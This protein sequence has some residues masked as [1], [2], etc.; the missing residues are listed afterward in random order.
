MRIIAGMLI[1]FAT[2]SS[3]LPGAKDKPD[4]DVIQG[5]WT[6]VSIRYKGKDVPAEDFSDTRARIDADTIT[7]VYPG[8]ESKE[9]KLS[10]RLNA[11]G[12]PRS[13]DLV[14]KFQAVAPGD[15]KPSE[16]TLQLAGIYEI[17]G[18]ELKLCWRMPPISK[19]G[20]ER[21][22]L[23]T[24]KPTTRPKNFTAKAN[25]VLTLRRLDK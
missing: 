24:G 3:S 13:I 12:L 16:R 5:K 20:G 17:N 7:F 25:Y 18:D 15:A 4:Q 10:Y 11:G 19:K 2:A 8:K 23:D 9:E 14:R 21:M 22:I 6:V 1:L